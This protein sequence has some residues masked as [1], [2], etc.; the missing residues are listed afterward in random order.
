MPLFLPRP[1][2]RPN[3]IFGGARW[4][5]P[6]AKGLCHW[7]PVT[8]ASHIENGYV[9]AVAVT[10]MIRNSYGS[11]A[12][13][14]QHAVAPDRVGGSAIYTT[15]LSGG[16]YAQANGLDTW[17]F[18]TA[19]TYSVWM[20]L[21]LA[22]P[23]G[24]VATGFCTLQDPAVNRSHYPYT[25][26]IIYCGTFRTS[27]RYAFSPLA[28]VDRATPHL[29]TITTDGTYWRFWQ[30]AQLTFEGAAD[31]TIGWPYSF[32]LNWLHST[33]SSYSIDGWSWDRRLYNRA[34]SQGE[35]ETLYA[36]DT[37]WAL[38]DTR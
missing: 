11:N 31:A 2:Q 30:N 10:D 12:G 35:I 32:H 26:G 7:W 5:H 36:P 27:A 38:Y 3:V 24:D 28:S 17:R 16:I 20:R 22:I 15:S 29:V 33:D 14:C 21:R 8:A 4:G 13:N 1:T 19:A 37:R 9:N 23:A 6:Q 25:D 34:L 18:S